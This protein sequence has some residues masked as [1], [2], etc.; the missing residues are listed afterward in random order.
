[1]R[2]L[3]LTGLSIAV[4]LLLL[5]AVVLQSST[6]QDRL[7]RLAV[8]AQMRGLD[9]AALLE[10]DGMRVLLCGSSSPLPHPT[11]AQACVAVFAGGRFYVVDTGLGSWNRMALWR[12]PGERIGAVFLTHFHSDHI[13]EL[14]ELNLMTWVA[15]RSAPLAVYGPVGVER[16]V[17]GFQEAYALDRGY[18]VAHHGADFMPPERGLM[19]PIRVPVGGDGARSAEVLRSDG[20]V[21]TAFRVDHSPISP[22]VGYRF[23]YAGRSVVVSGD[24]IRH[25]DVVAASRGADVLVHEALADHILG[26]AE[27]VAGELGNERVEHILQDIPS[28]HATPVEAAEVA[29]EAGVRLLVLYHLAPPPTNV[30]LERVFV[31]G[32]DAVRSDGVVLGDDGLV[33]D[34]PA[35]TEEV[36]VEHID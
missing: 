22:A 11:R 15:G 28:Y 29:N 33:V 21:V 13:G 31:R 1:M 32:V 20:L 27:E 26:L 16:V 5:G 14:G 10:G 17:A 36:G 35:G 9:G 25:A 6:L 4:V 34:L 24:T 18:R 19:Q 30:L 12:V 23:D 2:R 8:R 3:L 7:I